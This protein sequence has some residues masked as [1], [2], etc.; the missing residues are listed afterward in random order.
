MASRPTRADEER[1][2]ARRIESLNQTASFWL[3]GEV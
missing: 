3:M 1:E 2:K